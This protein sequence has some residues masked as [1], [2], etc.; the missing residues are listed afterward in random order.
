[1]EK[2]SIRDLKLEGRRLFLRV[3]FNVPLQDGKVS[4]DTRIRSSLPTI[5]W[6]VQHGARII[7]ASHLGRPKGQY[8]EALSLRPVAEHLDTLIDAPV[9]FVDQTVGPE[10]VTATSSLGNGEILLLENLRFDPGEISNAPGFVQELADLAEEYVNDAFGTA[11]RAHASTVGIPS[12]LGGGSAGL[13]LERELEYLSRVISTPEQPAVAI[14]GGA[15]VSDKIGVLQHFLG[16]AQTL[17][18]G[19]G[20]AFTFLKASGKEVGRSLVETDGLVLA[21]KVMADAEAGGIHL[22]VPVDVVVA[23]RCESGVPVSVVA[24]DVIPADWMGLD[25]G[26]RTQELF[27]EEIAAARTV[28]WNGPMGVFEIEEFSAGTIE[29]ARAVASSDVVSVVGGGDSVAAVKKAGV[30]DRITHISTGGGASLEFLS[31]QALPGVEVLS[32]KE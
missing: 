22:K 5:E 27:T 4:D 18:I 23:P 26:P 16:F 9:R 29:V 24:V 8:S 13:L 1:M 6:A 28:I 19:G 11:H 21:E 14:F 17:L 3:D 10:V 25:I 30:E 12:I 20:M 15:K 2:K 32:D 31:G 7:L